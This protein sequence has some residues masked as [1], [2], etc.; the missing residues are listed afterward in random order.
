MWTSEQTRW[1]Q[2]SEEK[3]TTAWDDL[4]DTTIYGFPHCEDELR[5]YRWYINQLFKSTPKGYHWHIINLNRVVRICASQRCDVLLTDYHSFGDLHFLWIQTGQQPST[6]A[7]VTLMETDG[8]SSMIFVGDGTLD[9]AQIM[10][11]AACTCTSAWSAAVTCT[12]QKNKTKPLCDQLVS[13]PCY[14]CL[15]VWDEIGQLN[16]LTLTSV[17]ESMLPLQPTPSN[18]INNAVTGHTIP[19]T[20]DRVMYYILYLVTAQS[21]C[22]ITWNYS[23]GIQYISIHHIAVVTVQTYCIIETTVGYDILLYCVPLPKKIFFG[24]KCLGQWFPY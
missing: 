2:E 4:I 1:H 16:H 5:E 20:C 21:C 3:A 24:F 6:P 19:P 10:L 9:D 17:T 8:H 13:H 23:T 11:Q 22:I 12:G 18:E 7:S 15:L 14:A